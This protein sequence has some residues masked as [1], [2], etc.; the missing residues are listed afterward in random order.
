MS[1]VSQLSPSCL[2]DGV[3]FTGLMGLVWWLRGVRRSEA[4]PNLCNR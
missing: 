3:P 1:L 4:N 2:A